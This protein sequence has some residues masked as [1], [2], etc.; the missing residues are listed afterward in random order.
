VAVCGFAAAE[1]PVEVCG[2]A[3]GVCAEPEVGEVCANALEA[4]SALEASSISGKVCV[5]FI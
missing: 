3:A 4:R 2:F 5:F 1:V